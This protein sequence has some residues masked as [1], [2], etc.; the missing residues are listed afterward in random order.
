MAHVGRGGNILRAKLKNLI[1][2]ATKEET[3]RGADSVEEA[4][5]TKVIA[6]YLYNDPNY[7]YFM[8]VEDY[9]QVAVPSAI[10]KNALPY[11]TEGLSVT[12]LCFDQKPATIE[13]PAK[14]DLKVTSASD[15]VRG[16]TAQGS[17]YKEVTL[18]TNTIFSAPMFIKEGDTIRI[19][20]DTGEYVERV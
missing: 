20:T 8:T 10:G 6:Q 19:N 14:V 9:E 2:G 15:A 3:F 4:D 12:I 18:E 17:G 16:N 13:L 1:T 5:I 11:I 7:L